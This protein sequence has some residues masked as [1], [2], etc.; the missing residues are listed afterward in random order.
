MGLILKSF[1]SPRSWYICSRQLSI[2]KYKTLMIVSSA[3]QKMWFCMSVIFTKSHWYINFSRTL[4][5][6]IF[7][8][9]DPHL[10]RFPLPHIK[11][12]LPQ[13]FYRLLWEVVLHKPHKHK[14]HTQKRENRGREKRRKTEQMALDSYLVGLPQPDVEGGFSEGNLWFAGR[15][16]TA[17]DRAL[18]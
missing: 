11:D 4:T 14:Q 2:L 6:C 12:W 5:F 10:V 7:H 15:A 13:S 18:S 3:V 1:T 17:G 16:C 9:A 8:L